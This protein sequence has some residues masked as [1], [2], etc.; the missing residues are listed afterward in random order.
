MTTRV[1][2][3]DGALLPEARWRAG[4]TTSCFSTTMYYQGQIKVQGMRSCACDA[5]LQPELANLS[6]TRP[7]DPVLAGTC[8]LTSPFCCPWR[9]PCVLQVSCGSNIKLQHVATGYRLH[10]HEVSYG[11]GSQQQSVTGYPTGDDG[12]SMW[13]VHGTKVRAPLTTGR[14][15][16]RGEGEARST[17][18]LRCWPPRAPASLRRPNGARAPP[19]LIPSHSLSYTLHLTCVLVAPHGMARQEAPCTPGSPVGKGSKLRLQHAGT[20]RWLHSHQ[21]QSPL[22]GN[23]EVRRKRKRRGSDNKERERERCTVRACRRETNERKERQG[24]EGTEAEVVPCAGALQALAG[25]C[26]TGH[27]LSH[28]V[29][30]PPA[31]PHSREP[32]AHY[33]QISAFGDDKRSDTGDVWA[34]EWDSSESHWSQSTKARLKHVDT[35]VYLYSHEMRFQQPIHGQ[36]EVCGKKSRDRNAEWQAAEGVYLPTDMAAPAAAGGK[37]KDEL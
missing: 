6:R 14:T 21:Y 7:R 10:S 17:R 32:L 26:P 27:C 29:S 36:Q 35:G 9:S 1:L 13:I 19:W 28:R 22:S 8:R 5:R 25:D 24:G 2:L 4:C 3:S 20:R 15:G 34:I 31:P 18:T 16:G 12:N 33:M 23:Q 11:R 30:L 37:T